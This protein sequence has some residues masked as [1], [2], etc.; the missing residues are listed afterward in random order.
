M[1]SHGFLLAFVI[2]AVLHAGVLSSNLLHVNAESSWIQKEKSVQLHIL[3][4]L[5]I[6]A[7]APKSTTEKTVPKT[8]SVPDN[9][10]ENVTSRPQIASTV[11]PE[12][13]L[14]FEMHPAA[15]KIKPPER[16]I[17]P[18]AAAAVTVPAE[19]HEAEAK[20][21]PDEVSVTP[22]AGSV[23]P[24]TSM[25]ENAAG[26]RSSSEQAALHVRESDGTGAGDNFLPNESEAE[27][28]GLTDLL[29]YPRYCRLHKQEGTTGLSVEIL[30]DGR[31]GKVEIVRSSGYSRLDKAAVQAVRK[32]EPV[33]AKKNGRNVVSITRIDVKFDLE[34]W[35]N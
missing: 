23:S 15:V 4:A 9:P 32:S 21:V 31:F 3:P 1:K 6:P 12:P 34:D 5:R 30:A 19:F 26:N 10:I 2:S 7:S 18:L 20:P 14:P 25:Q 22:P 17:P 8:D 13:K 11:K 33:P 24:G 35:G 28:Y 29:R 16:A 27:I